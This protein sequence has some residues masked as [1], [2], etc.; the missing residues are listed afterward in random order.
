MKAI[1]WVLVAAAITSPTA[2]SAQENKE[3]PAKP[4]EA[5]KGPPIPVDLQFVVTRFQ[6]EKQVARKPYSIRLHAEEKGS[7]FV[8]AQVPYRTTAQWGPTVAFKMIGASAS[9]V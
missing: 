6:G 4:T 2:V 1:L 5:P 9:A 7:F 3:A 8:G